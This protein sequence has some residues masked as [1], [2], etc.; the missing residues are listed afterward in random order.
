MKKTTFEINNSPDYRNLLPIVGYRVSPDWSVMYELEGKDLLEDTTKPDKKWMDKYFHPEDLPKV[1]KIIRKAVED[2]EMFVLE[3]RVILKDGTLGWISSRAIPLRNEKGEIYEWLG[4]AIDITRQKETEKKIQEEKIFAESIVESL[5]QPLLVLHSDFTVKSANAAF[6]KNFKV[7]EKETIGKL[8][9]RLGNNQWNIPGL[10]NLLEDVLPENST[11]NDYE[12]QH[13]FEDIGERIMLINAR[14][15]DHMQLILLGIRDVTQRKQHEMQMQRMLNVDQVGVLRFTDDAELIYA[16]DSFLK[17]TGY[18]RKELFEQKLGWKDFT[19][20]EH[21]GIS[22]KQLEKL[23]KTGKIGPYEK[24]YFTK[25]GSRKW[26]MF[27]GSSLGDG[28]FVEYCFDISGKKKAEQALE[29]NEERLRLTLDAMEIGSWMR[30]YNSEKLFIDENNARIFGIKGGAQTL[31]FHKIYEQMHPE[32]QPVVKQAVQEAW[33]KN[34]N[35][36]K[37]FRVLKDGEERWVMGR[38]KVVKDGSR[39][40]I[41][42]N[43]DITERKKAEHELKQA[44]KDAEEAAKI[45]EDFLAHMSHEIRTPLNS[46][47]GLSHLLLEQP[48]DKHQAKN[49]NYLKTASENLKEMI[50]DI[51][52][53][54]KLKSGKWRF[55]PEAVTIRECIEDILVTHLPVATGKNIKLETTIDENIPEQVITDE[56]KLHHVLNNLVSNAIK[57]THDGEVKIEVKLSKRKN[58][59]LWLE[60]S[61]SDTGIGIKKEQLEQIF[62]EF[63]QSDQSTVKQYKGTGLGLAIVKMYLKIM[64]SEI[65]VKSK[66]GKGSRFWFV[67]PVKEAKENT[68]PEKVPQKEEQTEVNFEDA[69]ILIVDDD[70]FSRLMLSQMLTMWGIPHDQAENGEKGVELAEKNTYDIIY[71]DVHMPV[72]D[73]IDATRKIRKIDGYKNKPVFALTADVT[74][75]VIKNVRSGLF[76]GKTIK[77]F[78]PDML[79][80]NIESILAAKKPDKNNR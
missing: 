73:G 68:E 67:L 39:K 63:S 50:D 56:P 10:R 60:F 34:S 40:M 46:V 21:V 1:K 65:K 53:Y 80:K 70:D 38:G 78:N 19:P 49:L 4:A 13:K 59:K 33:K 24:E 43:Y 71:I 62:D 14:R 69:R 7:N 44:K 58:K 9:Y 64:D 55:K 66:P 6:F 22:R 16:N 76:T 15:L 77:P 37:E 51:L 74:N 48:H 26:M 30:E 41:G 54:S 45:K 2:K 47:L 29:D 23:A 5:H 25:D 79:R 57:F 3:Q 31:N 72:M 52:D 42:I 17:M 61:V 8:I 36:R 75:K 27:A 32:D 28:T 12:V 20:E 18:T 11:F 35:F